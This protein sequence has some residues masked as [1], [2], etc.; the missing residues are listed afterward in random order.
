MIQLCYQLVEF[1]RGVVTL[2]DD[3][4]HGLQNEFKNKLFFRDP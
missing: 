2:K 3:F 4:E 1:G